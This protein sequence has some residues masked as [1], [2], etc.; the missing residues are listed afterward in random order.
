LF[1]GTKDLEIPLLVRAFCYWQEL[2]GDIMFGTRLGFSGTPSNLLPEELKPCHYEKGD[3]GRMI[4]YLTQP[5]VVSVEYMHPGWSPCSVL[6]RVAAQRHPSVNALIDTGALV[7]GLTNYE[8][9]P[10]V[11]SLLNFK[12]PVETPCETPVES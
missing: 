12:V 6:D 7:T 5:S 1:G 4:H 11:K 3:D 8:V 9:D 2:G 10:L